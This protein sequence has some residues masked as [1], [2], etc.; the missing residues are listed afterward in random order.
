MSL[1]FDSEEVSDEEVSDRD[2]SEVDDGRLSG[3]GRP[4]VEAGGL[5]RG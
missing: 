2:F 1:T 4:L 5:L 3:L